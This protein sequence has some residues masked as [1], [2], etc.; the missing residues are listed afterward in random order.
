M[1]NSTAKRTRQNTMPAP[2]L[3]DKRTTRHL[4]G[5]IGN[6]SFYKLIDLGVLE[7]VKVG[8]RTMT[9]ARSV[10]AAAQNLKK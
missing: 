10:H 3:Y 1:Q 2:L 9:T 4:L 8:G 6:T 5:G 7:K